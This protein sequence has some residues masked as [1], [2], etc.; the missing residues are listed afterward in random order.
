MC[1][2]R[3]EYLWLLVTCFYN[4]ATVQATELNSG[5]L[6]LGVKVSAKCDNSLLGTR[7]AHKNTI[8]V[9]ELSA[10]PILLFIV[11]TS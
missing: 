10:L 8:C 1:V 5:M 9:S 6:L 11:K 7:K 2:C 3:L 4:L